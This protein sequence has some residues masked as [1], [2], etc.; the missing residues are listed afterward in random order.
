VDILGGN[1]YIPP[2]SI[3]LFLFEKENLMKQL[4]NEDGYIAE[5]LSL[6]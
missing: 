2:G 4:L 6:S 5:M 1:I 3:M